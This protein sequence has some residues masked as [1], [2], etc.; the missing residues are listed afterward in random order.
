MEFSSNSANSL[1][2]KLCLR[3]V[4]Y[5]RASSELKET[6]AD[7]ENSHCVLAKPSNPQSQGFELIT[8]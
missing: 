8:V 7:A 3:K 2:S 4:L 1:P 5:C 6:S